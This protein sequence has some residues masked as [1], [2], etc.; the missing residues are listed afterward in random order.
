MSEAATVRNLGTPNGVLLMLV[1]PIVLRLWT[2]AVVWRFENG[3]Q[4]LLFSMMHGGAG[5]LTIPLFLSFLA[6]YVYALWVVVVVLL[7]VIPASRRRIAKAQLVVLSG[8]ALAGFVVLAGFLQQDTP[9]PYLFAGAVAMSVV[10]FLMGWIIYSGFRVS[11]ASEG[12][13]AV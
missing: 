2:E 7:W 10:V 12:K 11:S 9:K 6:I 4:M 5:W 1:V 13:S 8:A 3:L